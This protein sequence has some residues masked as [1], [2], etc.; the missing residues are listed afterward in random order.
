MSELIH[1]LILQGYEPLLYRLA[2]ALGQS[3]SVNNNKKTEISAPVAFIKHS[4]VWN[5]EQHTDNQF[6]VARLV[7]CKEDEM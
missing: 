7:K 6:K 2:T 4:S 5:N 1:L 3:T